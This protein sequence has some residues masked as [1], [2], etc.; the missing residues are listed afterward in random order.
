GAVRPEPVRRRLATGVRAAR[1]QAQ[2]RARQRQRAARTAARMARTGHG[3]PGPV[4]VP[5]RQRHALA[6]RRPDRRPPVTHVTARVLQRGT[7]PLDRAFYDAL[8][9]ARS[10]FTLAWEHTVPR[11]TGY[12]FTVRA[13]QAFRLTVGER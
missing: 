9:A 2:S 1:D 3:L 7:P 10:R 11:G 5:R 6:G 4:A 13:G 12:G 8:I